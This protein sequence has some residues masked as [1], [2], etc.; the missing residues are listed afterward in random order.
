VIENATG[1]GQATKG[2]SVIISR[3][4]EEGLIPRKKKRWRGDLKY[5][6]K[7]LS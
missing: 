2:E 4:R 5:S 3:L 7:K 6:K 1:R